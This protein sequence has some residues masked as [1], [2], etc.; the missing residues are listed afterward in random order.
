MKQKFVLK[1]TPVAWISQPHLWSQLLMYMQQK[2]SLG[3]Q[4]SR[5]LE[6]RDIRLLK[7]VFR[8]VEMSSILLSS[9]YPSC[10]LLS[11]SWAETNEMEMYAA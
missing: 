3:G 7:T 9:T 4:M 6:G 1:K 11:G 8:Y 10:S 2:A 5:V